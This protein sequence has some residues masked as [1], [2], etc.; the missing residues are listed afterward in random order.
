MPRPPRRPPSPARGSRPRPRDDPLDGGPLA[1]YK[2]NYLGLLAEVRALLAPRELLLSDARALR[3]AGRGPTS[4]TAIALA[5][6]ISPASATELIDRLE[7]RGLL[8]RSTDRTDRRAV[9]VSLT[10]SGSRTNRWAAERVRR[11]ARAISRELGPEGCAAVDHASG[12][13]ADA[14]QTCRARRLR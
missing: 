14:L 9:V 13:V 6:D 8:R 2:A 10:P 3:L 7:R 1:P 5:L 11:L 12:L 4:P